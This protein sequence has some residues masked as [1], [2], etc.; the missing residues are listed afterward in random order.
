MNESK[1]LYILSGKHAELLVS[2]AMLVETF[3]VPPFEPIR[4]VQLSY[5]IADY[6][7]HTIAILINLTEVVMRYQSYKMDQSKRHRQSGR[8]LE[9]YAILEKLGRLQ[10][11]LL[12]EKRS[13]RGDLEKGVLDSFLYKPDLSRALLNNA[14]NVSTGYNYSI[15]V[16]EIAHFGDLNSW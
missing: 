14:Y 8:S 11:F 15:W 4:L 9:D 3:E 16:L 2:N 10:I 5:Y 6:E 1:A 7:A 13:Q 12:I